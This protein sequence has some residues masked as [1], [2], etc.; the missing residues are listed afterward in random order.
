M[1]EDDSQNAGHGR[2]PW[3]LVVGP[4]AAVGLGPSKI[5]PIATPL[6]GGRRPERPGLLFIK[7]LSDIA[8]NKYPGGAGPSWLGGYLQ[9]CRSG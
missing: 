2:G 4:W 1:D 7:L 3:L 5:N 6:Q 9:L 8:R